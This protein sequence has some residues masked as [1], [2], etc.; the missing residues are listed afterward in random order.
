[1]Q[2]YPAAAEL[3]VSR[4]G[5]ITRFRRK[6][7]QAHKTCLQ[8]PLWKLTRDHVT[9]CSSGRQ[10]SAVQRGSGA[11]LQ[12]GQGGDHHDFP[13]EAKRQERAE[14]L[15]EQRS[16]WQS[17]QAAAGGSRESESGFVCVFSWDVLESCA[18]FH[19][20]GCVFFT[21]IHCSLT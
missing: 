19:F 16:G 12:K 17:A 8:V 6:K 1:M 10:P 2:R 14:K 4:S 11:H 20:R 18:F 21:L 5:C 7:K 3:S 13:G 9:R 15:G